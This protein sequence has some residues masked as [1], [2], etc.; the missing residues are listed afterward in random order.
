MESPAQAA[1]LDAARRCGFEL[2]GVA[3]AAPVDDYPV[4]QQWL[5]DG[6]AGQ[7]GYLGRSRAALRADPRALLPSARSVLCLGKLYKTRNQPPEKPGPL[8]SNYASGEKDY[9]DVVRIGLERLVGLLQDSWGAFEYRICVD[10]AP[11][12]ERSLARAAG[13]GWIGR[14]TCL[15]HEPT[16][17]WYFLGEILVSVDLDPGVPPPNR[18]GS[19]TRCIDACPTQALVPSPHHPSRFVLDARL[20]ISYLTIELRG[21]IPESLRPALGAHLFG[22]DIC[23]EV[24]PWNRRAPASVEPGFQPAPAGLNWEEWAA[25]TEA[26]FRRRFRSTPLWRARYR[27]LLR[28]LAVTLGN[29]GDARSRPALERLAAHPD[30]AVAS[31]AR[32][33]LSR[34]PFA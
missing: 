12:L 33:G 7:M 1:F 5:G 32:W 20:C 16:G 31:H 26:E 24:C 34:L 3:P 23:Q 30:P 17:S 2:A 14:N 8:L 10:T 9:H 21:D 18:C 27:G 22:C 25:L 19:C 4:Y 15:I 13:L 28:N 11:L 29:S 6:M